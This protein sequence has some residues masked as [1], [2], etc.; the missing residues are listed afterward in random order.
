MIDEFLQIFT[1]KIVFIINRFDAPR[2]ERVG[3]LRGPHL[4]RH[5]SASCFYQRTFARALTKKRMRLERRGK[6]ALATL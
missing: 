6:R 4:N 3:G 2:A 5:R 1:R